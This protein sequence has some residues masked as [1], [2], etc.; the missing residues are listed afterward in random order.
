M[1]ETL[2]HRVPVVA[3]LA[4]IER[5]RQLQAPFTAT[6]VAEPANRYFPHAIAVLSNGEKLGYVAPEIALRYF[7]PLQA[8]AAGGAP[9]A[10]CPG[11]RGSYADHETSGVELLLDFSALPVAAE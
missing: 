7:E 4:F 10:T 1:S 11:R 3:G 2:L 5:V 9:P 8:R 6:L